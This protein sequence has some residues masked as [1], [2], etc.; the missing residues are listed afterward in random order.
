MPP[1]SAPAIASL[2]G[3]K[4]LWGAFVNIFA[5][6]HANPT[7]KLFLIPFHG[8]RELACYHYSLSL[9]PHFSPWLCAFDLPSLNIPKCYSQSNRRETSRIGPLFFI[10]VYGGRI[11]LPESGGGNACTVH[12][13]LIS[14]VLHLLK[15]ISDLCSTHTHTHTRNPVIP[16]S[17]SCDALCLY[18]LLWREILSGIFMASLS[19]IITLTMCYGVD[20][21]R[22]GTYAVK[23]GD[24]LWLCR[25]F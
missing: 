1:S 5:G 10:R 2:R 6:R 16:S 12:L 19:L 14:C 9:P 18:Q 3:W 22:K 15:S 20:P 23:F 25:P 11:G 7:P 4:G 13:P 8:G 24:L 21:C 17:I